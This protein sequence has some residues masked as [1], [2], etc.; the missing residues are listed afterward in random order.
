LRQFGQQEKAEHAALAVGAE[1]H[2]RVG[3][4]AFEA[5]DQALG[6]GAQRFKKAGFGDL[7]Q[8]G[9]VIEAVE[10]L[11]EPGRSWVRLRGDPLP[12][13]LRRRG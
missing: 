2:T 3:C 8:R 1:G 10:R 11:P 4:S 13:M 9:A 7:A 6:A 12:E 5:I